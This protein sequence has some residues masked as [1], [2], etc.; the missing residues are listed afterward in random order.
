[1]IPSYQ[2]PAGFSSTYQRQIYGME[3]APPD[4]ALG[5][6]R[7]RNATRDFLSDDGFPRSGR[8][9]R[10]QSEDRKA[11]EP[12]LMGSDSPKIRRSIGASDF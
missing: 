11:V 2:F 1:M 8:P 3:P 10:T 5:H 9:P 4:P 7:R 6:G 12:F